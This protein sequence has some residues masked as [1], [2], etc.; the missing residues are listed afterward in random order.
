MHNQDKNEG[1]WLLI[2]ME[3]FNQV[4]TF[5]LHYGLVVGF[6]FFLLIPFAG[7]HISYVSEQE[8]SY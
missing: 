8:P 4:Y 5:S 2:E 7:N 1:L 3:D 6:L